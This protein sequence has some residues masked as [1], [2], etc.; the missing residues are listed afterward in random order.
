MNIEK[1]I[2][3]L[4][5]KPEDLAE[6]IL[7]GKKALI[8]QKAKLEAI[9]AIEKGF[10]AKEAAL[11]DTQDLAEVLLYAE[12][13]LGALIPPPKRDKESS[14]K[15]TS[16]HSLPEGINKRQ[17]HYA[18]QL[19]R[20]KEVI[21]QV[22]A[23]AR[24]QGEVPVRQQVLRQVRNKEIEKERKAIADKGNDV[25][26]NDRWTVECGDIKTYKTNKQFDYIITDP[27]YKKEFLGL[28][29]ILADRSN[30][31]LKDGGMLIA[32]C[33]Q[34]YLVQIYEIMSEYLEYYWTGCYL[35]PGQPKP[36][37]VKQ[38]NTIWKP[39]LFFIKPSN[40]YKGKIFGDV[41][42]SGANDKTMHKWGQSESGML[43][44]ISKI[45]LP[46]QSI[47]DPFLGSGTTGIV[48]K[49]Y[50][51]LFHGIDIDKNCIAL[52]KGRFANDKTKE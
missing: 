25:Q 29:G 47:F 35:T 52:S 39:L 24:E 2:S 8:A 50:G 18:Q 3:N 6:F 26:E 33:G 42:T 4:P 13:K 20:N 11:S 51:C 48:A 21:A 28:Y 45:C 41:F 19:N 7:V 17:S 1:R 30:E 14:S 36:M 32:M 27:P 9:Q 10:A 46:G 38:V 43:S 22:V 31:W 15:V 34:S 49:R 44:I 16:L 40:K 5:A 37:R 12:A 23:K